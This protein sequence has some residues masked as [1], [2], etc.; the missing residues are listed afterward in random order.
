MESY[1]LRDHDGAVAAEAPSLQAARTAA[2]TL[3]AERQATILFGFRAN[4]RFSSL[5]WT[6]D[7]DER[8]CESGTTLGIPGKTR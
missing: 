7:A 1:E 8:F 3:L 4:E 2:R 6:L 5:H